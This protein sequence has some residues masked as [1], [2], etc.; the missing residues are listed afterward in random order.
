M[1]GE[2]SQHNTHKWKVCQRRRAHKQQFIFCNAAFC[3][4]FERSVAI[5]CA[6]LHTNEFS[7]MLPVSSS[8]ANHQKTPTTSTQQQHKQQPEQ[9]HQQKQL[10]Q[11]ANQLLLE[12]AAAAAAQIFLS[13]SQQTRARECHAHMHWLRDFGRA[14]LN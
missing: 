5:R 1:V 7:F 2:W 6:T 9:R 4:S 8:K 13:I 10:V 12:A 14:R 11:P 3:A